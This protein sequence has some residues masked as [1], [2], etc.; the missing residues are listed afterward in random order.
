MD[1]HTISFMRRTRAWEEAMEVGEL[2]CQAT[3]PFRRCAHGDTVDRLRA[4]SE[5][6][7]TLIADGIE[8]DQPHRDRGVVLHRLRSAQQMRGRVATRLYLLWRRDVLPYETAIELSREVDCLGGTLMRLTEA[9]Q[10]DQD[11]LEQQCGAE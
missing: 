4:D 2:I 8:G 7:A 3:V 6:L 5:S 10:T 1:S 11:R 9:V